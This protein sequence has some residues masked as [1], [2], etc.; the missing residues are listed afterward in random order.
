M[1]NLL[2]KREVKSSEK[3]QREVFEGRERE[4]INEKLLKEAKEASS[5][6]ALR[7]GD[8][9]EKREIKLEPKKAV[10]KK[11][12]GNR[13]ANFLVGHPHPMPENNQALP[14]DTRV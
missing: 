8:S 2:G 7:S 6:D 3:E 9:L 5:V 12:L 13:K 11:I 4:K 14:D 1:R 10:F